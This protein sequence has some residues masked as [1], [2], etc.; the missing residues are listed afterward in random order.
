MN[1]GGDVTSCM[2]G[3]RLYFY[4]IIL[5][6][7]PCYVSQ[8]LLNLTRSKSSSKMLRNLPKPI[9]FAIFAEDFRDLGTPCADKPT[10]V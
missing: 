8:Y 3:I 1:K 7:C 10:T 6:I 5:D 2:L 9:F 4:I